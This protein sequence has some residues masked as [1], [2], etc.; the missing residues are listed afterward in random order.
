MSE[1]MAA[2]FWASVVITAL[3]D[4]TSGELHGFSKV[5]RDLTDRRAL[6]ESTQELNKELR[7]RMAQLAESAVG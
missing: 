2:L 4:P 1:R 3:R 5:T 6:E 7:N